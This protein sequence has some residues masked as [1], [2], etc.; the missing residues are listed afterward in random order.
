MIPCGQYQRRGAIQ[1]VI[2]QERDVSDSEVFFKINDR[3]DTHMSY[4]LR[5]SVLGF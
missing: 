4:D 1:K 5:L 2:G 3:I